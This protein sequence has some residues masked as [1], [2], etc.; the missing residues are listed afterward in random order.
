MFSH[1][2]IGAND[3]A[4]AAAFYD[5]FLAPLG[6][7]RFFEKGST[8][9]WHREGEAGSLY[10]NPPFDGAPANPGNGWMCA[11]YAPTR[12]A[13]IEAYEAALAH[14]GSDEGPPGP[15]P[16]YSPGYYGAYVR[17]PEGNKLHV[18]LRVK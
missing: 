5:A 7:V 9:G 13:V 12:E 18:V 15:R 17:D 4:R 14:G 8:I 16:H 10:V 2:T 11:F 1:I 6:I 3:V